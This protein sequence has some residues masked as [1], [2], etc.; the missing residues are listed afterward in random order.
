MSFDIVLAECLVQPICVCH[1]LLYWLNVYSSFKYMWLIFFTYLID[2]DGCPLLNDLIK[3]NCPF[4]KALTGCPLLNI[5]PSNEPSL[6]NM[7]IA[8]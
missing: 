5:G 7:S 4:L 2:L 6:N 1:S 3:M 8:V